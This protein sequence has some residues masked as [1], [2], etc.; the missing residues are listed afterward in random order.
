[1]SVVTILSA[2]E[3]KV[4]DGPPVFTSKERKRWFAFPRSALKEAEMLRTPTT[5][6]CFLTTY[7]YFRG[8]NKFFN[9]QF[10]AQDIAYVAKRLGF[11]P[12]AID[13]AWYQKDVYQ[14]HKTRILDLCGIREFDE[15]AERLIE[16]EIAVMVRSQLK[17][18]HIFHQVLDILL[19]NGI[20]VPGYFSLAEIIGKVMAGYKAELTKIIEQ[21]LSAENR[22]LLD[23]LFEKEMTTAPV[24]FQRYKLT[25]FKK[26]HQSTR[27][28]KV[29]ANTED[30]ETLR[31]LFHG[32]EPVMSALRLTNDGIEYYA[33]S[34]LKFQVFQMLRRSDEDRYPHLI[35]FIAHQY[36]KL[37]DGLVDTLVQVVQRTTSAVSEQQKSF[38]FSQREERQRRYSMLLG[39]KET[40]REAFEGIRAVLR[41]G[42]SDADKLAKIELIVSPLSAPSILPAE[43]ETT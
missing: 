8:C 16:K 4:F 30:L 10:H 18:K 14:D 36:F 27:P 20:E 34:V 40:S 24:K 7:G 5:K 41:S 6:V 15:T 23:T 2:K 33:Q 29:K 28:A 35:A 17:P 13:L 3:R 19:R 42:I 25:L 12:A 38:Y 32:L 22:Q 21:N 1:M 39:Y 26:F 37:Q 43:E 11:S 31:V 9:R